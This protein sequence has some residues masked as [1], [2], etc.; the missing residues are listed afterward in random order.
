MHG[1]RF[2]F[3][4]L[5]YKQISATVVTK[6]MITMWILANSI[7]IKIDCT[8]FWLKNAGREPNDEQYSQV[9]KSKFYEFKFE[10]SWIEMRI[11]QNSVHVCSNTTPSFLQNYNHKSVKYHLWECTPEKD[12]LWWHWLTLTLS[13]PAGLTL[14]MDSLRLSK[15]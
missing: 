4:P 10:E 3:C 8:K 11:K 5:W 9:R 13:E 2:H 14:M 1:Y 6:H 7:K 12:C 15:R